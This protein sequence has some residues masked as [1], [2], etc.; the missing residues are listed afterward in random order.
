MTIL[1]YFDQ[2][3]PRP[4][5]RVDHKIKGPIKKIIVFARLP[6]P[7][8]DYFLAGRIAAAGMP[9]AEVVDLASGDLPG[10]DP[11]GALVFFVGTPTGPASIGSAPMQTYLRASAFLLTMIWRRGSQ[12][13]WPRQRTA[14]TWRATAYCR[15]G[16]L[17]GILIAFGPLP[18]P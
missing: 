6:S 1:T 3:I 10:P 11:N 17:I 9:V 13:P 15:C 7:T 18:R 5:L 12:A 4:R 8:F 2:F 14:F 16:G